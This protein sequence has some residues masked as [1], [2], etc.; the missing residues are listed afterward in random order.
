MKKSKADG[1]CGES[2]ILS[3][4]A[5][6]RIMLGLSRAITGFIMKEAENVRCTAAAYFW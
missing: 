6:F 3:G 5:V 2:G 4:S 1:L